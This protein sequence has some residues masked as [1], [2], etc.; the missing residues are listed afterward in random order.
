MGT[1]SPKWGEMNR[2]FHPVNE[3]P[4]LPDNLNSFRPLRG[5][6]VEFTEPQGDAL[7]FID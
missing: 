7:G 2:V 4:W 3:S 1:P 5:S 6:G